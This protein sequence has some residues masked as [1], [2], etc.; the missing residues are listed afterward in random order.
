[1]PTAE[2]KSFDTHTG[3]GLSGHLHI[4]RDDGTEIDVG[5]G[6]AYHVGPSDT[7]VVVGDEPFVG[8]GFETVEDY[9][10]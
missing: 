3:I 1:M 10:K 9:A 4:I 7:F 2:S 5:P 6:D 8:Y